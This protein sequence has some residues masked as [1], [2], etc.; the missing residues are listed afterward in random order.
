MATVEIKGYCTLCRSRCG[1][2]NTVQDGRFVSVRPDF[3]HPT[4]SAMC[5]KGRAA[6]ELVYSPHRIRFPMRRTNPKGADDPGWVRISWD[7]A[8]DVVAGKLDTI[9][10][11]S[12]AEAVVFGVTT[13]SGTPLSDSID[14]VERFIRLYG[15][16]NICY[17]TE[18]CNWHKDFAHAFTFGCGMPSPD[19]ENADLVMLWGHNPTSTWLAQADAGGRGRRKGARLMVVDPRRTALAQQADVWLDVRPGTDGALAL[20]LI[21]L[22][23]ASGR[24]D[25]RFVRRWTN[26]PVLVR[27]DNGAFLREQDLDA[28]APTNRVLMWDGASATPDIDDDVA[29]RGS[30]LIDTTSGPVRCHPGFE[31]LARETS[32]YDPE[33]V[34]RL[35]GVSSDTILRAADLIAAAKRV[36]YHAWSGVGQHT[37]ATQ[38]ERAIAVLYALTGAFDGVGGNR[39]YPKHPTN[40][41][42][43]FSQLSAIQ[44]EKALGITERPIGPP[45]QGW[46]TARDTYHA[47]LHGAPYPV[48]AMFGF[49]SN[50]LSSQADIR[51]GES[52][53]RALEFHV[54]C[55]LFETPTA[56]YADILLPVGTPWEREGLRVGFDLNAASQQRV[57]L[58]PRIVA[59]QGEARA[60]YDIVFE[61]ARRLGMAEDFFGGSLEAGWNHMLAPTGMRVEQLRDLP[62]GIDL[63]LPERHHLYESTAF[64][65]ETARVELY[66]A[67]LHR[68][69]QPALPTFIPPAEAIDAGGRRYP[70]VLSSAKNGYFCHSQH[71]GIVSLRKR[72]LRPMVEMSPVTAQARGIEDG[73]P[74][75]I[76][77]RNGQARFTAQLKADMQADAVVG[78][79]GWWQA[80]PEIG[81]PGYALDG[82]DNSHYNGL[83]SSEHADP[84]SGSVP[85]RSFRCEVIRDPDFDIA[86]R[87]WTGWRPF[88]VARLEPLADGVLGI[89]F[90]PVDQGGLPDFLPGQHVAIRIERDASREPLLR[91]YSLTGAAILPGRRRYSIAVRHQKGDG[92]TGAM[93]GHLHRELALGDVVALQAPSGRFTLPLESAQPV[94]FIAGGIGITPFISQLETVLRLG[95]N[96]PEIVLHYANRNSVSHAFRERLAALAAQLPSLTVIDH[97]DAP[98]PGDRYGRAGRISDAVV[99]DAQIAARARIY[100]CGPGPM[101]DAVRAGLLAR[102]VP[103]FDIFHE[104]FVSPPKKVSGDATYTVRFLRSGRTVQWTAAS[105]TLLSLAE[106]SGIALPNGCRV[107]QCES[108]AV[109][110]KAG[111]ALHLHGE[112]PEDAGTI[113]ACQAIPASD[114]EIDA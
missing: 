58:R 34:A 50:I 108:C 47:I 48:R 59:P 5:M 90:E 104:Q 83:I 20:G 105:G 14:W 2:I 88:T 63:P 1:T 94:I 97:Y 62:G 70:L 17:A 29:L 96:V 87:R 55:D 74:V 66:S 57:Q 64:D 114:L 13:P 32:S 28:D 25:A 10:R 106:D 92:W 30:F 98:L 37:N 80:C 60:D 67:L 79:F 65:T 73:D 76:R 4:G 12:G 85:L 36:A 38:T 82:A 3:D 39:L 15:S 100:M 45:S 110:L 89:H 75:M 42:T 53:L 43:E 21:H 52:A 103:N 44:R 46:V 78:E 19:V 35:T 18:I 112:A 61:L 33:T 54:H 72:A 71:R 41:I 23:I 9:R 26:G 56:K 107:G 40:P 68:H 91:A 77:T 102:G 101:M 6:P 7:E 16:P 99:S 111:R 49:G 31:L 11:E 113:L 22:L 86:T 27:E 8:L 84:I 81:A 24:F 69:G 95:G 51:L 109:P 93:S